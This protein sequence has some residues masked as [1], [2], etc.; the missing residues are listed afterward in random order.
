[1]DAVTLREFDA[2]AGRFVEG[3]FV[4]PE[5]KG[6]AT[7]ID[8]DT[9]LVYRDF[10][11]GSLTTSG[12]PMTIRRLERGGDL[13]AAPEIFRGQPTDVS[14]SAYTLREPDGRLAAVLINRAVTF[15]E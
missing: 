1:K 8:G 9:L 7:W 15:Y 12:Y 10:G 5:S 4:L 6:G 11:E 3:G 2:A 14:V 13:D